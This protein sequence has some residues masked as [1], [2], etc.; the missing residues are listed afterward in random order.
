VLAPG[1]SLPHA[2]SPG[3]E[4]EDLLGQVAGALKQHPDLQGHKVGGEAAGG[5]RE[6]LPGEVQRC[7]TQSQEQVE[8]L[9]CSPSPGLGD[10]QGGGVARSPR[11]LRHLRQRGGGQQRLLSS[12]PTQCRGVEQ[13]DTHAHPVLTEH[14]KARN[15]AITSF[16]AS[17]EVPLH[18]AQASSGLPPVPKWAQEGRVWVATPFPNRCQPYASP[19]CPAALG[20]SLLAALTGAVISCEA[21]RCLGFLHC[22]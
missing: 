9:L 8:G 19:P 13:E 1:G 17:V 18:A 16:A 5:G 14:P 11:F 3:L 6:G 21:G 10:E 2:G 22:C 12:A 15:R 20:P 7:G 4:V